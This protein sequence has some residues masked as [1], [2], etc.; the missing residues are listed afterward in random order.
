MKQ[1]YP[2]VTT[3]IKQIAKR[4]IEMANQDQSV[5]EKYLSKDGKKYLDQLLKIDESNR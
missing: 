3:T 4:L 1:S 2:P 5:R